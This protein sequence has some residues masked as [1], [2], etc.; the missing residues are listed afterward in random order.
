MFDKTV[1]YVN[2]NRELYADLSIPEVL[3]DGLDRLEPDAEGFISRYARFD[4]TVDQD[5]AN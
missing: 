4:F 1:R 5:G 3:W 2:G